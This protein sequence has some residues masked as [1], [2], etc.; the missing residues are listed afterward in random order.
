[1]P[2]WRHYDEAGFMRGL[3]TSWTETSAEQQQCIEKLGCNDSYYQ[4]TRV[5]RSYKKVQK[6]QPSPEGR[7]KT[8]AWARHKPK[9][10]G[11]AKNTNKQG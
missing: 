11:R 10:S 2:Y 5:Q 1:M 6:F 8:E 4:E 7:S 3:T 9:T